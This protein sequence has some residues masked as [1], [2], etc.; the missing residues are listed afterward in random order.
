[1]NHRGNGDNSRFG[2]GST[3]VVTPGDSWTVPFLAFCGIDA[4][5]R[6]SNSSL[7]TIGC[8]NPGADGHSGKQQH[9]IAIWLHSGGR[10]CSN[11][12]ENCRT[13]TTNA[14]KYWTHR[15]SRRNKHPDS[16][17]EREGITC[18]R[19]AQTFKCFGERGFSYTRIGMPP[20]SPRPW[21]LR[22]PPIGHSTSPWCKRSS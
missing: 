20:I 5:R 21:R 19:L 15:G 22:A 14:T 9:F 17:A 11:P 18:K 3:L 12:A 4:W 10:N 2:G 16:L 8:H 7:C 6:A 1:M 13:C